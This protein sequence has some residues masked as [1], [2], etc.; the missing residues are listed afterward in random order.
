MPNWKN[1]W[2]KVKPVKRE[3]PAPKVKI[4]NPWPE[5]EDI[6]RV[7]LLAPTLGLTSGRYRLVRQAFE[8]P[9]ARYGIYGLRTTWSELR[10]KELVND[11]KMVVLGYGRQG[12]GR[13]RGK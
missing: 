12:S 2:A 6:V 7:Y 11:G 13:L 5:G 4:I 9:G 10:L 8:G 3:A 1:L